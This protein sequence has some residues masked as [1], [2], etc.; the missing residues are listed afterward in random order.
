MTNSNIFDKVAVQMMTTNSETPKLKKIVFPFVEAGLGHIMPMRAVA[1]AF[2]AK[3]GDKCIVE[4][5]FFF[6]EEN[7]PDLKYIEEMLIKEVYKH[8]RNKIHG[9]Y[10]SFLMNFLGS[11]KSIRWLYSWWWKRG[12][13]PSMT[14]MQEF[15]ADLI[16]H[17]HFATLF[18]GCESKYQ[19]KTKAKNVLYCPDPIIGNQWDKRVDFATLSSNLGEKKARKKRGFKKFSTRF[20]T[21]PFLIR[22]QI[23]E[24]T[25]SRIEYKKQLGIEPS[26]FTILLADG[27]YGVGKLK[28]TVYELLKSPMPLT[29]IPVCGK[30]EA[31]YREFI[32]ITPPSHI[33]LKPYGFTDQMLLLASSCDLFIGKAGA[34]NL[35]EPTYF[36]VP[37]IVTFTATAIEKWICAHYTK[38]LGCT[39]KI[40]N[41]K[42]AVKLAISFAENPSLMKPLIDATIPARRHDGPE[43]LADILWE[44]L[45]A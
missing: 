23:A 1:D 2:E 39:K 37:S 35:A 11:Q 7:N 20:A 19:G 30:N 24:Y 6:Q 25:N 38:V 21:V 10:Q 9:L 28:Q 26:K 4:R 36:G 29:I 18:Y 45:N 44:E 41:I 22:S 15:D 3:Y 32:S 14:R 13:L 31:L 8:N 16:F 5:T 27:A 42:K 40:T 12:Y 17:T 34:S 33:E 43:Q